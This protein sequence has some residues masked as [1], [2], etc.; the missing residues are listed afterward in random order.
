MQVLRAREHSCTAA[1]ACILGM[2]RRKVEKITVFYFSV[3]YKGFLHCSCMYEMRISC[4]EQYRLSRGIEMCYCINV[5]ALAA[6]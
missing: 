1:T 5:T 4:Q 3:G 6:I 2:M